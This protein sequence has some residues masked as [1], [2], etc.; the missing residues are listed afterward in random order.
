MEKLFFSNTGKNVKWLAKVELVAGAIGAVISG[1]A[2]MFSQSFW[3]GLLVLLGGIL[4]AWVSA[5]MI[6]ALG[7]AAD[8]E[9]QPET[10]SGNQIV[11]ASDG[12]KYSIEKGWLCPKCGNQNP[13]SR[14]SCKNC[15]T[16]KG[17]EVQT[18]QDGWTCSKC[19]SHNP[20]S[21]VSC[22]NCGAYK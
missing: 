7:E 15:G 12:K 21:T 16:Q 20:N 1:F 13:N 3:L 17:E 8:K 5:T 19:G 9:K 11:V 14:M 4:G 2:M 18:F 6:Y 10:I 22:K